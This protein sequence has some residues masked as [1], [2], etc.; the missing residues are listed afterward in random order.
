MGKKKAKKKTKEE[1]AEEQKRVYVSYF[2]K[3]QKYTS[4]AFMI[5]DE[6]KNFDNWTMGSYD[7]WIKKSD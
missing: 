6:W 5:N 1:K 2:Y 4:T 7:V 3:N